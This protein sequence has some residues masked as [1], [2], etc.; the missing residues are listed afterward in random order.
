MK[1]II[2]SVTESLDG[3]NQNIYPFFPYLL[4]DLNEFGTDPK[5]VSKIIGNNL[6]DTNLLKVL[7][8]GCGK[9]AVSV[10]L[11]NDFSCKAVGIDAIPQFIESAKQLAKSMGVDQNTT[12]IQGDIRELYS[13]NKG[14]DIVVLGA[15]GP[16]LGNLYETLEKVSTCLKP[17][18][19]VVL[20][21]GYLI[22]DSSMEDEIYSTQS[23]FYEH[24]N[25]ARYTTVDKTIFAPKEMR[26][27]NRSIFDCILKR[28]HE[29]ISMYPQNAPVLKEYISN[30]EKENHALE[31]SLRCGVWLLQKQ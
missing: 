28:A 3:T 19:Y 24:I 15:I 16:V 25:R 22:D 2:E 30:Q 4:Q 7:D 17:L 8:L 21:D 27:Q 26:E 9:G 23:E 5:T 1:N 14:F 29:L 10:R 11:A 18:G 13:S 20:D 31:N 12:F 6:K